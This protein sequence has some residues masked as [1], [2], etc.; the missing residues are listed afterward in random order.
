MGSIVLAVL[1]GTI[2]GV[3]ANIIYY[4][5]PKLS[6]MLIRYHSSRLPTKLSR[7]MTEEWCA[8]LDQT[9]GNIAKLVFA[10]DL[11]R[12]ISRINREST[13]SSTNSNLTEIFDGNSSST[14]ATG[15][16]IRVA[17]C[18]V[19]M[20]LISLIVIPKIRHN[21]EL[22][23]A[24]I[25]M[26]LFPSEVL[27]AYKLRGSSPTINDLQFE[28][29]RS[30][31]NLRFYVGNA[32]LMGI[33][34]AN[35]HS[36]L[37]RVW[38]LEQNTKDI[39]TRSFLMALRAEFFLRENKPNLAIPILEEAHKILPANR[40]I[41]GFLLVAYRKEFQRLLNDD[42]SSINKRIELRNLFK[43]INQLEEKL[44]LSQIAGISVGPSEM[45]VLEVEIEIA[46]ADILK[47]GIYSIR[48]A[49]AVATEDE[50]C[51]FPCRQILF[52]AGNGGFGGS[53]AIDQDTAVVGAPGNNGAA[54]E[55]GAVYVFVP[56]E[57]EWVLQAKLI[58]GDG[59]PQDNFGH[60][61]AIDGGTIAIGSP[62]DDSAVLDSGSVYIFV[63]EGGIW[64]LQSNWAADD[65]AP[66]DLF[67]Y[68]ISIEDD[69]L[70]IAAGSVTSDS[71]GIDC[72]TDCVEDYPRGTVVSLAARP[73]AGDSDDG[74]PGST[75]AGW[76]G[77]PDCRDGQVTMDADKS[78]AANL[79]P[80]G[81]ILRIEKNGSGS[82]SVISDPPGIACGDD[83]SQDFISGTTVSLTAA[84][85]SGSIFQGWPGDADCSDGAVTMIS[86]LVCTATFLPAV[87]T[88]VTVS[89]S[90]TG[91]ESGT[92]TSDPAGIDCGTVCSANYS[93]LIRIYLVAQADPGSAFIGWGGDPDCKDGE[94]VTDSEHCSAAFEPL[95]ATLRTLTLQVTGSGG[96]TAISSPSAIFCDSDCTGSFLANSLVTLTARPADGSDFAGW[97]GDEDCLDGVLSLITITLTSSDPEGGDLSFSIET[98]PTGGTLSNLT[99][100]VP[101]PIPEVDEDGDPTGNFIQP[102]VISA[103]VYYQPNNPG[104][105]ESDSFIFKVTDTGSATGMAV[106][107]IN[108]PTDPPQGGDPSISAED[109][110]AEVRSGFSVTL[111]LTGNGPEGVTLAFELTTDPAN[112][113]LT[114]SGGNPICPA[115]NADLFEFDPQTESFITVGS[116][117][118]TLFNDGYDVS[119]PLSLLENDDGR[120][121]FK[122]ET[123]HHLGGCGF[124]GILDYMPD[125]GLAPGQARADIQGVA[126]FNMEFDV[127]ALP[128]LASEIEGATVTL[129]TEK[130]T[131]NSYPDPNPR[132]GAL[133]ALGALVQVPPSSATVT[134]TAL[135]AGDLPDSFGF[136]V[137]DPGGLFDETVVDINAP[138]P[139]IPP[140][141]MDVV[142]AKD[143][144]LEP[145]AG[146]AVD[147]SLVAFADVADP[148]MVPDFAFTIVFGPTSGTLTTPVPSVPT[149]M[150]LGP[151]VPED[152]FDSVRSATVTY[153]PPATAGTASFDFQACADLDGDTFLCQDVNESDFETSLFP[154]SGAAMPVPAGA[155]VGDEGTF[156]FDV[157]SRVTTVED[158]NLLSLQGRVDE[159]SDYRPG[160]HS[161]SVNEGAW[162][163]LY[164]YREPTVKLP[165]S[166]ARI[167][168]IGINSYEAS[169]N[170]EPLDYAVRDTTRVS[171]AFAEHGFKSLTLFDNEATKD[172]I[173]GSLVEEALTSKPGE[174]FVF[175]FAGH[176]FM[177]KR[178]E[179]ALV[180]F[181]GEFLA[182]TDVEAVLSWHR[183][184]A[185][186]I[187]DTCFHQRKDVDL[188][189][190]PRISP[191]MPWPHWAKP[192][193]FILAAQPGQD[194]AESSAFRSGLFTQALLSYLQ[195][196]E[197]GLANHIG[198]QD[199]EL[200]SVELFDR[201]SKDTTR[202]STLCC[203]ISQYP[204]LHLNGLIR[205][206]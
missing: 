133:G 32:N 114:D 148:S 200:Y 121:T 108:P 184:K 119:I 76:S 171:E 163:G 165:K 42:L 3:M 94:I 48:S 174:F 197:L 105:D 204:R 43:K 78:C 199:I 100:I 104:A 156:Q 72:G 126:R 152:L 139:A 149:A 39:R 56:N 2:S 166:S 109:V 15:S 98:P 17:I 203:G 5:L 92:V 64:N 145:V 79:D 118:A 161:D 107:L 75:F 144:S 178:G 180:T 18:L 81:F 41:A 33:D 47:G 68:A 16:Q 57:S 22:E 60:S 96:G 125:L 154:I 110:V 136:R 102:P 188:G 83:C 205:E 160:L 176:G 155:Q 162:P 23:N 123:Q 82:G 130:W 141:L 131:V 167:L 35:A 103:I 13:V 10:L 38:D 14:K 153:T 150:D 31:Q 117:A 20:V 51:A 26:P 157:T 194:A 88:S 7:R 170:Y 191:G 21:S 97:S 11:F 6:C 77:D 73:Q 91:G 37:Q 198:K 4:N 36:L 44:G 112:G 52:G 12:A 89:V 206:R 192:V 182:L 45:A 63:R 67:G 46:Q 99:E 181:D 185:V 202:L 177:D 25:V 172:N 159:T 186:V 59:A 29:T 193:T 151:P 179:E 1:I 129:T 183:G 69:T 28:D 201:V 173:L 8:E 168:S 84:P 111:E 124:T 65:A 55:A 146:A 127:R 9:V 93:G 74:A 122:V 80:V 132:V 158:L 53:V 137:T 134:Y 190:I 27:H 24:N 71:V 70:A 40:L 58:A 142:V 115:S 86:D 147:I 30:E 49:L 195:Q 87:S 143:D 19:V 66:D 54:S 95:S 116:V 34:R 85:S 113:T 189:I 62:Q 106:V 164:D 169:S 50:D 61:V 196:I 135:A 140:V 138:D 120:M 175:Y 128:K 90:K 187:V 101:A